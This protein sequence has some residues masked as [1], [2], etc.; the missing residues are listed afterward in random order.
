MKRLIMKSL[1]FLLVVLCNPSHRKTREVKIEFNQNE[2]LQTKKFFACKQNGLTGFLAEVYS[3]LLL[4]FSFP[5]CRRRR[6]R[7]SK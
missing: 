5:P 6:A 2:L 7:F 4:L 1:Y 3:L